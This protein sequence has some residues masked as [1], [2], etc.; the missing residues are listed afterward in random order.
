MKD[1]VYDTIEIKAPILPYQG[2]FTKESDLG[3]YDFQINKQAY[4]SDNKFV[5][6]FYRSL[7]TFINAL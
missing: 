5:D 4:F 7:D 1:M 6:E 2:D 3:D